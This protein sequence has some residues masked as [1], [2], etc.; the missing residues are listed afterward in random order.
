MHN[1]VKL[2][3]LNIR[4]LNSKEK[5]LYL[6]EVLNTCHIDI[7]FLQETHIHNKREL[8][9]L[10]ETLFRYEVKTMLCETKSKGVAI[11]VKKADYIK[12]NS[13]EFDDENRIFCVN[14]NIYNYEFNLVN[15]YAPNLSSEQNLFVEKL[16]DY[17]CNKKKLI[18]AGDFNFVLDKKDREGDNNNNMNDKSNIKNWKKFYK[19]L[20]LYEIDNKEKTN[21]INSMMSWT[22]GFQS[23]RIDRIYNKNDVSI[24]IKY[25]QSY[26]FSMS[27]HRMLVSELDFD[28]ISNIKRIKNSWK[29]NES[30]F[31][32]ED[33]NNKIIDFCN[34]IPK[35]IKKYDIGWYDKF[36]N[37][38]INYLKIAC[39]E[40]AKERKKD[41]N[42]LFVELNELDKSDHQD[43]NIKRKM[44]EIRLK[45]KEYFK[46]KIKGMEKRTCDERMKFVKQPS[47]CLINK[48]ISKS[49]SC[50]IEK[51]KNDKGEITCDNEEIIKDVYNFY[52]DLLGKVKVNS[53]KIN[54]YNFKIKSLNDTDK[55]FFVNYKITYEEAYKCVKEMDESSP[56]PNGMTI[57]FYKRYFPLFGEYF[58]CILNSYN[59]ELPDAFNESVIKLIPKNDN[60]I[61]SVNDLRPISLTNFEYRIFTK[62]LAN[63]M[64]AVSYKI[65]GE[66]QTCSILGRKINDNINL[67]RD[68]IED[69]NM[70]KRFLYLIS[71]DQRKA[72]DSVSHEYL[73]KLIDHM[74]FG[75]FMCSSIKRIYDNSFT[76]IEINKS[77][78]NKFKIKSG[79]KQGCALSMFLYVLAIEELLININLN[80]KIKGYK[81]N[82]TR[83]L[84]IKSSAYA[85]DVA[86]VV[87]DES[88]VME[89]FKMF[90][91][92]GEISGA[93]INQEKTKILSV[94]V[95]EEYSNLKFV[96]ELKILGIIFN[97]NGISDEN[98]N[99]AHT[100]IEKTLGMWYCVNLNTIERI[101]VCK[102]FALSKLW[103]IC[104]F[105][106][107]PE[108]FL[109]KFE[110]TIF[111][112]IWNGAIEY[113]KR[114]T[115]IL[116]YDQGGL[117]MFHIR[118]KLETIIFQQFRN[119]VFYFERAAY[120]LSVYWLKF[121]MCD[122]NLKNFNIIPCGNDNERSVFYNNIIKCVNKIKKLDKDYF[123]KIESYTSKKTYELLVKEKYVKPKIENTPL[124]YEWT[125]TYKN[126]H[127]L[128]NS[129]L[130]SVNYKILMDALPL[131]TRIVKNKD[132]CYLCKRNN[133][134]RDH[135]FINC[136][137]VRDLFSI[138]VTDLEVKQYL[139]YKSIILQ[140]KQNEIDYLNISYFK[141]LIWRIRNILRVNPNYNSETI[142]RKYWNRWLISK[143][144]TKH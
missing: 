84:E 7:C 94:N 50:V 64:R 62:I 130:R 22:N 71:V 128:R 108:C 27:D 113:I 110:T 29:L 58:V 13:F 2:S 6:S 36:I 48:E 138:V 90:N 106:N 88:S 39:R 129:D 15:V 70:R 135:L 101:V 57:G 35:L 73:Y 38:I 23:S 45:L 14:V 103:Y 17:V 4:G 142:F 37:F 43:D 133:E 61:K 56:G 125:Q 65:I 114:D 16:Y 131:N 97:K 102:T 87:S 91:E 120:Q 42:Q 53:E 111:K 124:L 122:L 69:A 8:N 109:K 116:P 21:Q 107:I 93:S 119:I 55:K 26:L 63:R 99:K 5:V 3:T 137:V 82:V 140:E 126:I 78:S 92:W 30:V 51:Y 115:L 60:K 67:I 96:N 31:E 79:I 117:N 59:N 136:S 54:S 11:L 52:E 47:K 76:R 34:Q 100:N 98:I 77:K 105:M 49:K 28:K 123:K 19:V 80:E 33:V 1:K 118:T 141:F 112:F 41:I 9:F 75:E 104:S 143:P 66:H 83:N 40:K 85:D 10:E 74:N 18:L 12:I 32:Y 139:S 20:D 134:D 44:I 24:S 25:M 68:I 86:G 95:K 89:F 81:V 144:N 121:C 127:A 72:F 132:K 46:Q